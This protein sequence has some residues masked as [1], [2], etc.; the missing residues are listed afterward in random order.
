MECSDELYSR[1]QRAFE[2]PAVITDSCFRYICF[3]WLGECPLHDKGLCSIHRDKGEDFLPKICRLYPRSY[4]HINDYNFVSCSSSCEAVVEQLFD[5]GATVIV[6]GSLDAEAELSYKVTDEDIEKITRYQKLMKY[7]SL[8]LPESLH[9]ICC[10]VNEEEFLR[11][12][13]GDTDPLAEAM[14]ILKKLSSSNN[15]LEDTVQPIIERYEN[16]PSLYEADITV[17]EKDYPEWMNFFMNVI[18]NSM[19]Y[20]CF[21]FVDNRFDRTLSYK[22]LCVCYGLLRVVTIGNHHFNPT[23]EGLVDA[24]SALFHLID[25]TSFYY[26]INVMAENAAVMLK[27]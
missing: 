23:R 26:N 21:P 5:D 6:T 22:G 15:C 3:N 9:E 27:L 24:V 20:G 19:L 7:E 2:V 16:D 12:K 13:A 11:D 10:D 18:N 1:V 17:F 25:H 4:K 8:T 14:T